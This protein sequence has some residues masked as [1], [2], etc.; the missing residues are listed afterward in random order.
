M[1]TPDQETSKLTYQDHDGIMREIEGCSLTV[2]KLGRHWIWSERVEHNLVYK[3]KGLENALLSAIDS[4]LFTV[5]L[6][7]ERIEALQRIVDLAQRFADEVK[8]DEDY[9]E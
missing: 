8:P 7:D 9:N 3:T 5:K 6:R 1:S 2:D 4:L